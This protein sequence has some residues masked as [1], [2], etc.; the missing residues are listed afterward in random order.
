MPNRPQR[1][2][3]MRLNVSGSHVLEHPRQKIHQASR[4]DRARR[5]RDPKTDRQAR[6]E[7]R[8]G[9]AEADA[10]RRARISRPPFPKQHLEEARASRPTCSS[11]R[12]TR[13]R[14]TRARK[15]CKDKVALITGGDSGIGRA[16]AVLYARE[17]ADVAIVYL[18]RARG[19]RG[20]QARRRGGRP[21]LHPA[22]RRRRRSGVLRGGRAGDGRRVRPARH[23]GQQRGVPAARRTTSRTS[24]TS[25]ST[26]RS[27]PTSTA[28]STWR[29]RRCR[30]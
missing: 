19:R 26:A 30:T 23:P 21:A 22:R 24:P 16:V 5:A 12:C 4:S 9:K 18:E 7:R 25:I 2:P 13:R 1:V 29:R 6:Q 8:P 14:T 15:S 17:G 11:R 27:R 10:G 20:D 28:I 3:A